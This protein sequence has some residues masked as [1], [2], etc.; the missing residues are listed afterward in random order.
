MGAMTG[1]GGLTAMSG[2]LTNRL[3]NNTIAIDWVGTATPLNTKAGSINLYQALNPAIANTQA[4]KDAINYLNPGMVRIHCLEMMLDSTQR[5]LGW[6][7]NPTLSTYSWDTS[8]ITS[9]LSTLATGR[10]KMLTICRFP[11]AISDAQGKLVAGKTA[12]FAAFCVQLLQICNQANVGITHLQLLNELDTAYS[13][14]TAALGT[15]W[16]TCRDAIKAAFPAILIGGHS[17]ANVYNNGNVDGFLTVSKAKMDFFS[18]NTYTTGAPQ[19]STPQQLWNSAS[20]SIPSAL[21]QA[22]SRLVGQGVGAMPIYLTEVGMSYTGSSIYNGGILRAI[23]EA[24][25]LINTVKN[26]SAGFIGAWNEADD[27]HGLHSGPTSGY[28][29]RPAAHLYHL[30]NEAIGG[31]SYPV[32]VTGDTVPVVS[33]TP[34]IG[35]QALAAQRPDGKKVMVIVNRSEL[36][37]VVRV[38]H[39]G[40]VPS[41]GLMLNL[42]LVT[43]QGM[44]STQISYANFAAGYD[45]P[46]DSVTFVSTV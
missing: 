43:A 2:L 35:V 20:T 30:W 44:Q 32:I 31:S 40:W 27:S 28:Q 1:I 14:N 4:Y 34:V 11:A 33:S 23:W 13:G 25:R 12:E 3:I 10:T 6:V 22:R 17:F 39:S 5:A 9:A 24:L 21:S 29:Q 18:F 45:S 8:K 38:Q 42:S 7:K 41:S 26:Q 36:D 37:R 16:N 46:S 19:N 15:I